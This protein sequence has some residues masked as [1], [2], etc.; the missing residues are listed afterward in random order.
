MPER[1]N[2]R[3]KMMSYEKTL[4]IHTVSEANIK[5]HWAAKAARVKSQRETAC[6]AVRSMMPSCKIPD[7]LKIRVRLLR[8]GK[9]KLDG[10]NLQSSFKAI[11]DGIADAFGIDD[12]SDRYEW[13][14]SQ[15]TAK[16]YFVKISVELAG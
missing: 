12:G 8:I 4:P 10:D 7:G 15:E 5:E 9:R 2:T 1:E 11:R 13:N 16:D 14:Y 6:W 3:G